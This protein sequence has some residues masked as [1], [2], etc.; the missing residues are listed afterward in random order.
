MPLLFLLCILCGVYLFA[1]VFDAEK[2]QSVDVFAAQTTA[3]SELLLHS[4]LKSGIGVR[5]N[6][7]ILHAVEMLATGV[8]CPQ[9]CGQESS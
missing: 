4:Q 9:P 5:G 2:F 1:L 3:K 8:S 6:Y 7:Y